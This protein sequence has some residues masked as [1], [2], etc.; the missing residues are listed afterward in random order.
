MNALFFF[1][2]ASS[3][4]PHI[5]TIIMTVM[6]CLGIVNGLCTTRL[7]KFFGLTDWI[8]G[9]T[10]A[11]FFL[12]F[13]MHV[14]FALEIIFYSL[15]GGYS[16]KHLLNRFLIAC[17]WVV[18]NCASVFLGAY[19]GYLLKRIEPSVKPSQIVRPVPAQPRWFRLPFVV[20][21]FGGLQYLTVC[22]E[23]SAVM[24]SLWGNRL[25]SLFGFVLVDFILL[26]F[27]VGVLSI[28]QT[29]IQLQYENPHWM[30]RSFWSGASGGIF[31]AI[32][33][34]VYMFSEMDFKNFDGDM[35]YLI[36]MTIFIV[37]YMLMTGM[38]SVFASFVFVDH[39]YS[40][41]KG[42]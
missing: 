9:A 11:A 8:F 39:L 33:A 28:L 36:Y 40:S 2:S 42:E 21:V 18:C 3:Y 22:V 34:V 26:L 32:H 25:Y 38:I 15:A 12:P 10:M 30:W 31:L 35:V 5:F 37:G 41:I 19:K 27:V 13:F 7:L 24:K 4:R 14:C 6:A 1:F 29:Y 16:S 17:T 20:I 23:F